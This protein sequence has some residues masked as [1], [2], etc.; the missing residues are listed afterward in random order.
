MP[1]FMRTPIAGRNR[2]RRGAPTA[3][4]RVRSDAGFTLIEVLIATVVLAVGL[5]GLLGL[6]DTSVKATAS[7][8]AREGAVSLARQVLEDAHTIP[9]AQLSPTSV[10]SQLQAM[11]GLENATPGST[12]HIARRESATQKP[13]TYTVAAEECSVDDPKDGLAKE[14]DSTY[15]PGQ[16]IWKAGEAE[17][18]TP[19]DFKRVTVNVTWSAQGRPSECSTTRTCVR[20][21][22]MISAAGE[23]V[24]LSATELKLVPPPSVES[25]TPP[26]PLTAPV[27][28]PAGAKELGKPEVLTFSVNAPKGSTAVRWSLEGV[29]QSPAPEPNE[30]TTWTFKWKIEGLSD[31]TYQVS[32]QAITTTGVLGPPVT[33]PVTLVRSSPG[34]PKNIK[35]GFNEVF[36]NGVR[37]EDAELQWEA[38]TEHNIIGYRVYRPGSLACPESEERLSLALT[39]IDFGGPNKTEATYEIAAL[40]R[41]AEGQVVEGAKATAKLPWPVPAAPNKPEPVEA[42]KNEDGSVTLTWPKVTGAAFYRIYRES[43]NYASRYDVAPGSEN[44][45]YTDTDA[46]VAHSYWVTAVNSNMHESA[47]VGPVT[48]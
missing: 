37:T 17:D 44:P 47:P 27:I 35:A 29:P 4:S 18:Q 16:P 45:S 15:C 14:H 8:R 19:I 3:H 6:L 5:I 46:T 30:G 40:Y 28:T 48:K 32:A 33:I 20:E 1:A 11:N 10:V 22:T 39:C 13:I 25:A 43:R 42:N 38:N 21:V 2:R 34:A 24:G 12:W 41:N 26:S 9:F 31:G 36:V 7:T 23:A